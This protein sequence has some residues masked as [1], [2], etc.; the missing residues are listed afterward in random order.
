MLRD[1]TSSGLLLAATLAALAAPG[2]TQAQT[3]TTL[4]RAAVLRID[5]PGPMPIS[6][7]SLPAADAGFAGGNLGTADNATTGAFMKQSF[8]TESLAIAPDALASEM[9]RLLGEG[10]QWF[11]VLGDSASVQ[12]ASD[13]AG[14]RAMVFNATATDDA[15]RGEN[16]RANL[17]HIAPSDAM[18]SDALAQYLVWKRWSDWFLIEGSHP[19]DRALGA[20]YR[21]AADKF[22]ARITTDRVFEDTGGAR[23]TDSG[24]VQVQAQMPVFTQGAANHHVV[25][26]ADHSGVFA[27]WLPYHTWD[28][29]PV[30]GSAGL[31]PV[32]WHPAHEAWGATQWQSRFEKLA[33]RQATP[34]DFQV[35]T[36]LRVVGEAATRTKGGDFAALRDHIL[37]PEFSLAAFKG[38]KLTFRDWDGQLRQPILLASDL[39]ITSVSPQEEFLHQTSHLDTLGIDRQET[40]CKK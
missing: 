32:T 36:A 1:P 24:H 9:E 13:L 6:R 17:L 10:V 28:A 30:T 4:Y 5:T 23:R 19:Q 33:G 40:T 29:R 22:G 3:D 16:C 25:V 39:V 18:L 8:E 21:R 12:Q 7:L 35:W 34:V 26:A 14:E 20:A 37:S 2:A 15:L 38:Q 27:D 31:K 11:V